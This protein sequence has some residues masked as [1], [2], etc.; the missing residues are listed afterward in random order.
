MNKLKNVGTVISKVAGRGG[1]VVKK[2]S[3]EILMVTG[4]VGVVASTVLAC[5]ATLKVEEV[6]GDA[7]DQIDKIHDVHDGVYE[8]KEGQ[9]YSE[10]DYK[11]DLVIAY[12][13]KGM[14]IIKL[15]GPAVSLGIAS[16]GCIVGSHHIMSK[17]NIALVAAYKA[18]EEAFQQYRKRVI[19]EYGEDK[20]HQLKFGTTKEIVTEVVKGEDGKDKKVKKTIEKNDPNMHSQYARFFDE[21]STQWS[22]T[23]EYNLVFLKCQQNFMNDLLNTRGHVFL[24]EVYDAL[25]LPR[26][27][28]GAVVGWVKGQG[29]GY[30]D[31]GMYNPDSEKARDFVNG[32]ERSILLDFNV[33]G[34]IY[35]LI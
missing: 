31:F 11:R 17:R 19:E 33:D 5:K 6:V 27:Q 32:Y 1:L 34:V 3:P 25:G 28:A 4:V 24:N 26:S 7:D 15:Y 29:D 9:T 21:S 13:Q 16:I 14:G 35:D 23:P 8:L 20:D 22:K 12:V 30:I 2:Y 18:T 10:E